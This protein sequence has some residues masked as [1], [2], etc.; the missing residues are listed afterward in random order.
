[1]LARLGQ[2]PEA[3]AELETALKIDAN[4]QPARQML[5]DVETRLKGK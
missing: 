1:M 3:Q 5:K 4:F 2:L